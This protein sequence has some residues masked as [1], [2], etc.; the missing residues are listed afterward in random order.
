M[1]PL[2]GKLHQYRAIGKGQ[3]S[4]LVGV[5]GDIICQ[6]SAKLV[7]RRRFLRGRDELPVTISFR[8]RDTI[9]GRSKLRRRVR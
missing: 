4:A 3:G 7:Q 1:L 2:I 9:D 6:N 5:D 8:K